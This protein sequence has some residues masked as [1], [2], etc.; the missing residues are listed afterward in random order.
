MRG[1]AYADVYKQ[2]DQIDIMSERYFF[3]FLVFSLFRK[4]TNITISIVFWRILWFCLDLYLIC[5]IIMI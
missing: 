3:I 4:N 5:Y 1:Q 2:I